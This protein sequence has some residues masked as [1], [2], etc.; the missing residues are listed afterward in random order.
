MLMKV[1]RIVQCMKL[2]KY[3]TIQMAPNV[4]TVLL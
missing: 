1:G 4:V 3:K 2:E